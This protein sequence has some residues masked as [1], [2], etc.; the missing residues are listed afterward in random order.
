MRN[1]VKIVVLFLLLSIS[2]GVFADVKCDDGKPGATVNCVVTNAN[3][4]GSVSRIKV[5]EGL[6]FVS[7]DVCDDTTYALTPENKANFKFKIAEEIAESKTLR[8]TFGGETAQIKV[9]IESESEEEENDEATTYTITLVPGK[10]QAN[11][12]KSCSVNSLNDTC[13]VTLD[14]IENPDFTGWGKEKDCTQGDVEGSI[15]VN[16]N[17][18]Y[19]AC[20]KS[21]ETEEDAQ[22]EEEQDNINSELVLKSLVVKN[23]DDEIDLGFSIR[24]FEYEIEVPL[25]VESLEVDA[26]AEHKD[27]K[28]NISGN[29]K[30][31]NATNKIVVELVLNDEKKEYVINVLKKDEKKLPLLNNLVIAGYLNDFQPERFN[32]TVKLDKGIKSLTID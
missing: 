3:V 28:I 25:D 6:E 20:Y 31:E 9:V 18:T 13:N 29:D 7:C 10:G 19:Y 26:V 4:N 8:A 23:G 24:I 21:A 32:Y 1:I 11:K 2:Q 17:I 15:K 22:D 12:T 27:V 5:D 14:K 16:K 30:L